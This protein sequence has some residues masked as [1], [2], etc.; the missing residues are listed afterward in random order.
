MRQQ[1]Q[2]LD[3]GTLT[4]TGQ[5]AEMASFPFVIRR[6]RGPG[7]SLDSAGSG[8]LGCGSRAAPDC[9][10]LVNAE[11]SH[12]AQARDCLW[13]EAA[14][15]GWSRCRYSA[16]ALG[17]RPAPAPATA[18]P[19]AGDSARPDARLW[20]NTRGAGH[21]PLEPCSAVIAVLHSL[22][23]WPPTR[24]PE[25]PWRRPSIRPP[26]CH[27]YL[28]QQ[29]FDDGPIEL[30]RRPDSRNAAVGLMAWHGDLP[31][32]ASL[33]VDGRGGRGSR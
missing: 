3:R 18:L 13:A 24:L 19:G 20:A 27:S 7:T 12:V 15:P 28:K 8:R 9:R 32:P 16:A 22:G 11:A 33:V 2:R 17:A 31:Q 10:W 4:A 21:G 5:S 23:G 1:R 25:P 26:F 29:C 14:A 6:P 30:P